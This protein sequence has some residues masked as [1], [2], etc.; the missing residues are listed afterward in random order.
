MNTK[1]A[2]GVLAFAFGV[3]GRTTISSYIENKPCFD[4]MNCDGYAG[5]F[6]YL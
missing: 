6:V 2:W 4:L 3:P 5:Y 1:Y